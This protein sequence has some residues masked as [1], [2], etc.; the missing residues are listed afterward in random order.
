[1]DTSDAIAPE[2]LE[3]VTRLAANR[4][5]PVSA[6]SI[7]EIAAALGISR[8]TLYRRIGSR[9][10]L[11]DTLKA[12]GQDPGEEPDAAE[13][14][15]IAATGL[16]REAGIAAL[17]LEAVA[18]RAGCALPT[19]YARF[20]GRTGLLMAVFERQSPLPRLREVL[21]G[22]EPADGAAL[23]A[24]VAR[25]YAVIHE[26]FAREHALLRAMLAEALRDP[27]G[28]VGRFLT[29]RYLP[30]VMTHIMPWVAR[31]MERGLI[32]PLPLLLVG[33]QLAAPIIVHIATRPLVEASGVVPLPPIDEVCVALADMFCR[34]VEAPPGVAPKES[35]S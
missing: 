7:D 18:A 35:D 14:A 28:D 12:G 23:R 8:M 20:G 5:V 24:V 22:A 13:R 32:R 10:A 21:E 3:I 11:H 17:T 1:M 19:I 33:Q 27:A 34:A 6:L 16:I 9:R 2:V 15:I 25:V 29:T 30:G 4:G 26:T 31:Q